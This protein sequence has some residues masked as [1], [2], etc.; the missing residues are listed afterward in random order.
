MGVIKIIQKKHSIFLINQGIF[1]KY[2]TYLDIIE[3]FIFYKNY[4]FTLEFINL[5]DIFFN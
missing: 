1:K 2:T 5:N 4:Y 3:I